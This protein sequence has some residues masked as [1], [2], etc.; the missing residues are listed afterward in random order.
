M[1]T[2]VLLTGLLPLQTQRREIFK[3][4]FLIS[5]KFIPSFLF[6]AVFNLPRNR[7]Q[8]LLDFEG[9][10]AL[11]HHAVLR[12]TFTI[13]PSPSSAPPTHVIVDVKY[14]SYFAIVPTLHSSDYTPQWHAGNIYDLPRVSPRFVQLPVSPSFSVPTSYEI[15]ISGD[16]EVRLILE[17]CEFG[18]TRVRVDQAL[19]RVGESNTKS[20]HSS[21]F[22]CSV[23]GISSG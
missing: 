18:L 6:Y 7:W 2:V 11:Q 14:G 15:W 13:T 12:S 9:W 8:N 21:V 20:N 19:R 23:L 17:A 5:G 16:Y 1:Q 3:S 10:A 22:A 4:L